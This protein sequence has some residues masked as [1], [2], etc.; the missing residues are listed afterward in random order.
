MERTAGSSP[1]GTYLGVG[2][3]TTE[4][5]APTFIPPGY[6]YETLAVNIVVSG[7]PQP[8]TQSPNGPLLLIS[9]RPV[10]QLPTFSKS[11]SV[12]LTRQLR[13]VIPWKR[14]TFHPSL[15][16]SRSGA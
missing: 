3:M 11:C 6:P 1:G 9:C 5:M 16:R 8:H 10:E 2:R 12:K 13:D 15:H 7:V 14:L 4:L